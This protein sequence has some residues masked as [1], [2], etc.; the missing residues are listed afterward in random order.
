MSIASTLLRALKRAGMTQSRL[1]EQVGVTQA[2]ISQICTGKRV[3]TVGTLER[4]GDCLNMTVEEFF[5]DGAETA[6]QSDRMP[7]TREE[8]RLLVCYRSMNSRNRKAVSMLAE[9]LRQ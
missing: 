1:A 4:I 5:S 9:Q 3:P 2:Y 8:A 6:A 7:L